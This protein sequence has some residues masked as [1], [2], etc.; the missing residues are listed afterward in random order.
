VHCEQSA[1]E[2]IMAKFSITLKDPDYAVNGHGTTRPNPAER[3]VIDAFVEWDE[4]VTLEF[5]TVAK[6][7]RVVPV[8]EGQ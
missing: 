5:D 4:Y 1:Q 2:K 6:T 8:K 7:A 3:A